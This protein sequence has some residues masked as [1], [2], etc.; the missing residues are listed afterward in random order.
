MENGFENGFELVDA[1]SDFICVRERESCVEFGFMIASRKVSIAAA[2]SP[3]T[4]IYRSYQSKARRFALA[5]AIKLGH[6]EER[7]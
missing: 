7:S 1:N 2:I 4:P 5:E 6:A 3:N